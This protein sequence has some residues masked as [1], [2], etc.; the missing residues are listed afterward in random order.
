MHTKKQPP[1]K[2][3]RAM[4]KSKTTYGNE[5]HR[6]IHLSPTLAVS[7][8]SWDSIEYV[9]RGKKL[10]SGTSSYSVLNEPWPVW[11][12]N[13]KTQH[14]PVTM[15]PGLGQLG[16]MH[17]HSCNQIKI[18]IIIITAGL[19]VQYKP[20]KKMPMN[21]KGYYKSDTT[22]GKPSAR[23]IQICRVYFCKNCVWPLFLKITFKIMSKQK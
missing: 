23:R 11:F 5:G 2:T 9:W 21:Q 3:K 14:T 6:D 16:S 12:R 19:G 17:S 20:T 7:A 10:S 4:Y 18:I 8:L 13:P 1:K 15:V 22:I